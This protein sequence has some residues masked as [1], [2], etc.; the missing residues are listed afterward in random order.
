MPILDSVK[1]H[2]QQ[3][4][5]I[6]NAHGAYNV[7]IFGSIAKGQDVPGSDLDILS[8]LAPEKSLLDIVAIKQDL[9]DL[10]G[11][12]V[13]VVTQASLSPYLKSEI[14]KSAVHL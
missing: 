11:F 2:R 6:T 14:L 1:A 12:K 5:S 9:E 8:D 4:L 13:D 10:L 7:R 3:I